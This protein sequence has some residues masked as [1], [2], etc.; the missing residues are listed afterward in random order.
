V[1]VDDQSLGN[2]P[3]A[4]TLSVTGNDSD[5]NNDLDWSARWIWIRARHGIQD[6]LVVTGEGTWSVDSLGNVTFAP[7]AGFTLTTRHRSRYTVSD[8]DRT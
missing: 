5:P 3:G 2:P 4:V 6:T 8:A 1:A 7:E